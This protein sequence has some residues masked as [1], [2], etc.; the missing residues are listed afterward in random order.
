MARSTITGASGEVSLDGPNEMETRMAYSDE[1]IE[2]GT[3]IRVIALQGTRVHVEAAVTSS[4][5]AE[6]S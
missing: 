2:P 6:T 3:R 5:P 4:T 1:R